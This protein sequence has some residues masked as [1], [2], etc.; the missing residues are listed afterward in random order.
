MSFHELYFWNISSDSVLTE[1]NRT[2]NGI[3]YLIY[4]NSFKRF[5]TQNV[6]FESTHVIREINGKSTY[7]D[8]LINVFL[9]SYGTLKLRRPY[10]FAWT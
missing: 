2:N 7:F 8:G 9:I 4:V 10:Y 5:S 1:L 3:D 6:F